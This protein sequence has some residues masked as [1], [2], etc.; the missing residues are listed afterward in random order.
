VNNSG[1]AVP[2][3]A[4]VDSRDHWLSAGEPHCA[5]CHAA[6]YVEQSGNISAYPPFNYPAKT[7]LMRYTRGHQDISCQGCHESIHG[8]YPVTPAIDTTSYAQAAALNNDGS[9]GPLKCATCH[10]FVDGQGIPNWV[11]D[12]TYNDPT[13]PGQDNLPVAGDFDR[14]VSWM[15]TYTAEA[16]P[17]QDVCLNCH[18][19]ESDDISVREDEW[20]E[21]AMTNRTSRVAM[22][23][24]ERSVNNGRVFGELPGQQRRRL[25]TTC[26]DDGD[27]ENELGEQRCDREWR[28]HL[29][30]GRISP[31]VWEELSAP[32]GGCGW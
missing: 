9:H 20:L 12:L 21:H 1:F 2:F 31:V 6:P 17:A 26:H 15:H 30:Q 22:D 4:A 29:I 13:T 16:N 14:A 7:S 10:T 25:C 5:D 8:L 28:E 18:E 32:L 11:D 23:N 27:G 19:D 3:S 24:A